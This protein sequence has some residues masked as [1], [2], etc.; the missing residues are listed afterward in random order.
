MSYLH[1]YSPDEQERLR[2]QAALI[3]PLLYQSWEAIGQPDRI[4]EVGCGVGAQLQF[5]AR[6]YPQASLVGLDHS[7]QQLAAARKLDLAAE[8]VEGKAEELPFA[9]ESFDLVCL[10]WVLEHLSSPQAV[11]REV[12]RVLK[13]GGWVALSEVHNP[14]LYFFP[15]CPRALDYWKRY[16]ELQKTLGGNP[17]V[18]V[19]LP[20]LARTAGLTIRNFRSFAPCLTGEVVD[21]EQRREIVHFWTDLLYSAL[22]ML[23]EHGLYQEDFGGIAQELARLVEEPAAVIDYQARQLLAQKP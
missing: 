16:N 22:A 8:W 13:P 17:E 5:L 19:Q 23:Q 7:P 11:L 9:S 18:G 21:P 20:Y 14:S 12:A 15:A 2:R 4:L 6:R 1:T 3:Q 10:Y